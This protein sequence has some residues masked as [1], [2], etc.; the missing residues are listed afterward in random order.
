MKRI[1]GVK[2]KYTHDQLIYV[3]CAR[4]FFNNKYLYQVSSNINRLC[5][6]DALQ[7]AKKL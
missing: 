2:K 1:N 3:G 6:K 7:D 5:R 4:F